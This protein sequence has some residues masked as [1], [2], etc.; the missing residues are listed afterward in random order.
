MPTLAGGGAERVM[1]T[2]ARGFLQRGHDVDIVV[3][4]AEGALAAEVPPGVRL[5]ELRNRRVLFS[6]FRLAQYIRRERPATVLATL[7]NANAV[8]VMARWMSRQSTRVVL[9]QAY[10]LTRGLQIENFTVV[11]GILERLLVRWCF[12]RADLIVAVSKGVAADLQGRSYMRR[13]SIHVAPNPVVTSELSRLADMEVDHPWFQPGAP[14]VV[15]AVGRLTVA[16]RFD[17][18]IRAF[19]QVAQRTNARLVILGEGEE[20]QSLE[21]LVQQLGIA[22]AAWL[23]GFVGNPF[24]AMAKSKVFVL[25]S[26][27]EGLPGVLI[28]ALACGTAVVAT[29]CDSGPREILD[30]GRFGRLVPVGNVEALA[31][32]IQD[33]LSGRVCPAPEA[34]LP[35]T[36]ASSVDAYLQLLL[37]SAN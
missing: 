22:D 8:A 16:K 3:V 32:A 28:Q 24:P 7:T 29:D 2:L 36:E 30:E 14:P 35:Y 6:V 12:P 11:E 15:L 20:R 31:D 18:L 27:F 21:A 10:H 26:A 37:Q 34:C 13:T 33:A 5:I 19:A 1:L 23:P 17:I 9:R 4:R 25:S